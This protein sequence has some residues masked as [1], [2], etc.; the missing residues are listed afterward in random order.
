MKHFSTEI[1]CQGFFA[2]ITTL[3]SI[4]HVKLLD[5]VLII[6]KICHLLTE[7]FLYFQSSYFHENPLA[8]T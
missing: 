5:N 8:E 7:G 4:K 2:A 1:S 3:I 6:Y